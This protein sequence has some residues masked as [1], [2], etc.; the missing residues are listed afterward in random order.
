[1]NVCI[2]DDCVCPQISRWKSGEIAACQAHNLKYKIHIESRLL[3]KRV[4][5]CLV[6]SWTLSKHFS[7]PDHGLESAIPNR[8]SCQR[9]FLCGNSSKCRVSSPL[10]FPSF[11]LLCVSWVLRF[12]PAV[13]QA[14]CSPRMKCSLSVS[15]LLFPL[16]FLCYL[17]CLLLFLLCHQNLTP[18]SLPISLC[19]HIHQHPEE[20]WR[21]AEDGGAIWYAAL[22]PCTEIDRYWWSGG[23]WLRFPRDKTFGEKQVQLVTNEPEWIKREA[24]SKWTAKRAELFCI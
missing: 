18:Y 7:E 12:P 14:A 23:M 17:L 5:I 2:R 22:C 21:M 1:M 8:V 20:W 4:P 19:Q 16:N 24:V 9:H 3:W 6:G 10:P 13:F 15:L 11:M